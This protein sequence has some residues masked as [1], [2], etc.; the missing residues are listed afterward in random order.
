M[1]VLLRL[2]YPATNVELSLE[3]PFGP[4]YERKVVAD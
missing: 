4:A 3:D 1:W 2:D